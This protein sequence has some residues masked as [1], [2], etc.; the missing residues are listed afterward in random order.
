MSQFNVHFYRSN[1]EY[2]KTLLLLDRFNQFFF[3]NYFVRNSGFKNIISILISVNYLIISWPVGMQPGLAAA[4][5]WQPFTNIRLFCTLNAF[6]FMMR[7]DRGRFISMRNIYLHHHHQTLLYPI[8]SHII[9]IIRP[10][11]Q[12]VEFHSGSSGY[13]YPYLKNWIF[14]NMLVL[15]V[16]KYQESAH[17]HRKL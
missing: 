9:G 2:C 7:S 3:I 10:I 14:L 1:Q 4:A 12:C 11:L 5:A 16:P 8:P 15:A 17:I 6:K 13:T